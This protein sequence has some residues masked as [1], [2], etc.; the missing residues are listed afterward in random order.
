LQG[1]HWPALGKA[2]TPV[3]LQAGQRYPFELYWLYRGKSPDD[4]FFVRLIADDGRTIAAATTELRPGSRLI[5]EQYLVEDADLTLPAD[6]APG[7]YHLQI[8][9]FTPAVEAGE[10]VFDLPPE[11][12]ALDISP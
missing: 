4:E 10:L 1:W 8:G 9:F 11:L 12:T 3:T 6:I 5:P 7:S 2:A